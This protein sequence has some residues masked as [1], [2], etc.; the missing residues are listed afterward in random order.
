MAISDLKLDGDTGWMA[1]PRFAPQD[2]LD[3]DG[4]IMHGLS[5]PSNRRILSGHLIGCGIEAFTAAANSRAETTVAGVTGLV[6]NVS[7]QRKQNTG[8]DEIWHV[9]IEMQEPYSG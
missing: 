9:T 3:S 8:T 6:L 1:T 2:V 7:G 4:T 5:S